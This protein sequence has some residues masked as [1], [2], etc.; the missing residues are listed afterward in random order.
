[1]AANTLTLL[2]DYPISIGNRRLAVGALT[3]PTSY[4]T[5]TTG[6][7]PTG[8]Q[9]I[10]ASQFGMKYIESVSCS[11]SDDGQ[12]TAFWTPASASH[13]GVTSGILG[14][15]SFGGSEL[16]GATNLSART[17]RVTVIGR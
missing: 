6:S 1:M 4:T 11:V 12:Y 8:G 10:L 7:P 17:V 14:W 2:P 13:N 16:G 5:I 9:T 15:T 3:G